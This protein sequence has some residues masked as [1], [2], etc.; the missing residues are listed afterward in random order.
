MQKKKS[1]NTDIID[2]AVKFAVNA[3]SGQQRKVNN[4]PYIVHPMEAVTITA[5]MT[6]DQ[7]LLAAAALH[8]VLEDTSVTEET[9]RKEFGDRIADLVV[10]ESEP[11]YPELPRSESWALRKQ[12]ALEHLE[13]AS[14]EVKM[15]TMG[16]KLSNMRAIWRSYL[17]EGDKLW[18]AFNV[19][20][21]TVQ[22]QYYKNLLKAF[23]G[24]EDTFAY[25]EFAALIKNM[26]G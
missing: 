17:I 20:D 4:V 23:K 8:D 5:T 1:L 19:T 11:Q 3:H 25:M 10:S 21:A 13:N 18:E 7:E 16:D 26:W 24:L 15:V 12:Y 14:R 2:K 9:V 22:E 6:C